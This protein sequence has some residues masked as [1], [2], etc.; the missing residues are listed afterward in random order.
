MREGDLV[1][2]VARSTTTSSRYAAVFHLGDEATVSDVQLAN[3]GAAPGDRVTDLWTG[4]VVATD[5]A[6]LRLAVP[7]HGTRMLRLDPA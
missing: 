3:L 5:G 4:E 1:L 7:A 6:W 2:W